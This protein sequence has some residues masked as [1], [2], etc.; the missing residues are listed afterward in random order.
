MKTLLLL[1]IINLS[2]YSNYQELLFN[3]N[4]VTCHRMD[5]LNK[6][7]PTIIEIQKNYKNAFP[8]KEDFI[9]YMSEWVYDP[10]LKTSIMQNAIKKYKLMPDLAYDK[11]TLK[12][13]SNYIYEK[14]FK[15]Q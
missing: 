10:S 15:K 9:H 6:S 1:F 11:E 14:D 2:L 7:A 5:N 12:E 4:C 3:G 8:K 13:I